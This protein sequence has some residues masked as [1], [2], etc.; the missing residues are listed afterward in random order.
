MKRQI[1]PLIE[2]GKVVQFCIIINNT[3]ETGVF[4]LNKEQL[5]LLELNEIK[6]FEFNNIG[7]YLKWLIKHDKTTF[8]LSAEIKKQKLKSLDKVRNKYANLELDS[9]DKKGR[10]ERA[11]LEQLLQTDRLEKARLLKDRLAIEERFKRRSKEEE[12]NEYLAEWGGYKE[13]ALDNLPLVSTPYEEFGKKKRKSK[14]KGKG[15]K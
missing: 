8:D 3:G 14:V 15:K 6:S 12:L 1:K 4:I 13:N 11:R 5:D 7:Y 2:D 10:L 9:L